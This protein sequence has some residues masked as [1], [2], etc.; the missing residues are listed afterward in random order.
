[1]TISSLLRAS[2]GLY[3]SVPEFVM[4]SVSFDRDDPHDIADLEQFWSFLDVEPSMMGLVVNVNPLWDGRRL[5]V[6]KALASIPDGVQRVTTVIHY[7]MRWVDFSETR[8]CKVGESGRL[9]LRSLL[10]GI[11]EMVRITVGNDAVSKWHLGG[12]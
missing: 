4:T 11:D 12:Y 7:M 1:M 5:R 9:Y 10:I 8:W 6:S 3:L 2:T